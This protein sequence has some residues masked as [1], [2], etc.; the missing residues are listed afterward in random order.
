MSIAHFRQQ[1]ADLADQ[2]GDRALDAD[3]E[4]WLNAERLHA[5]NATYP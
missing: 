4:A 3:L 2:I 1:I 5:L